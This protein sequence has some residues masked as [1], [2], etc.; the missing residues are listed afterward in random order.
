MKKKII[1]LLT[2][3]AFFLSN[4]AQSQIISGGE[5]HTLSLCFDGTVKSWGNN[6]SGQ[7]GDNGSSNVNQPV[8]VNSVNNA[9]A[10]SAGHEFSLALASDG[11]VWAWGGNAYGQ[12]G[13]D[14]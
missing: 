10:V 7:L 5:S 14:S 11:N 8:S 13:I 3:C 2:P 12:L 4:M 9:I 6:A 1:L